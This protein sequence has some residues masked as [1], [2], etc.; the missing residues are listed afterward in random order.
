MSHWRKAVFFCAAFACVMPGIACAAGFDPVAATDR[1]LATVPTAMRARADA[2]DIGNHWLLLWTFLYGAAAKLLLLGTGFS[3]RLRDLA[4]RI[5]RWR[6]AAWPLYCVLYVAAIALIVL[7]FDAATGFWRD[8]YYGMSTETFSDWLKGEAIDTLQAAVFVPLIASAVFGMMAVSAARWWFYGALFGTAIYAVRLFVYPI[9]IA[10]LLFT[11]TPLEPGPVRDQVASLA[12]ANGVPTDQIYRFNLS[13][14]TTIPNA[15]VSGIGPTAR[16][17]LSDNL[18]NTKNMSVIR[19][20]TGH[21]MG[22]YV[23]GHRYTILMEDGLLILAL[24][25]FLSFAYPWMIRR[26]GARWHIREAADIA[27]LPAMLI[28]VFLFDLLASPLENTI[29]RIAET[30]ADLFA[31]NATREVDAVPP[32]IMKIGGNFRLA[33][34][35]L[36]EFAFYDHPSVRTRILAAMRWKAENLPW[37]SERPSASRQR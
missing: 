29:N 33:P 6:P 20:I 35:P 14:L 36:E 13:K 3:A 21:E 22:H 4:L 34:E 9:F 10:P 16:I 30:Q 2:Y 18:I 28:L 1:I 19:L 37:T 24:F 23:L 11:L 26:F 17:A 8:H 25:G 31:F 12:R 27:G 32:L 7:P 5:G 15:N